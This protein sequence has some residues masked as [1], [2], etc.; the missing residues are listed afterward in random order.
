MKT[1]L[2][3]I[4]IL[5]A[6]PVLADGKP[7]RFCSEDVDCFM[8]D[9]PALQDQIDQNAAAI[10]NNG[11]WID[12]LDSRLSTQITSNNLRLNQIEDSFNAL[13]EQGNTNALNIH[14]LGLLHEADVEAAQIAFRRMDDKLSASIAASSALDFTAPAVNGRAR[15]NF[16]AAYYDSEAAIG[17]GYVKKF[18]GTKSFGIGFAS[19]LSFDETVVKGHFGFDVGK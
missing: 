19:D 7:F 3:A 16:G 17:I 12:E 5:F 8:H 2:A 4:L 13:V 6:L 15:W 10:L 14:N 18:S 11:L 9:H 1:L